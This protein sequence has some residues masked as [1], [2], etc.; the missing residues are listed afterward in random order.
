MTAE[1]L[2]CPTCGAAISSDAAQCQYCGAKLATVACPSCFGL[3]FI[4]SKFCPHCGKELVWPE[5][6]PT[7]RRCPRC[8]TASLEAVALMD[9]QLLECRRCC[10]LWLPV[11]TF[12]RICSEQKKQAA[13][14]ALNLP[15]PIE[16]KPDLGRRY[17]PC[18]ACGQLMNRV[19]FSHR[20]GII[21]DVCAKHGVWFDRDELRGIIEFIRSGGLERARQIEA[22]KLA[23]RVRNLESMGS[24]LAPTSIFHD[25]RDGELAGAFAIA[26]AWLGSLLD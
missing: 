22:E 5:D 2:N 17:L 26:G 25:A 9:T 20:S 12:R 15:P 11:A 13:V 23:D 14:L 6:S 3:A 4:G 18:P 8:A 24:K 1:T 16:P 10:G 7:T 19:N 21:I